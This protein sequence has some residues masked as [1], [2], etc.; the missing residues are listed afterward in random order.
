MP[1]YRPRRPTRR[2][3]EAPDSA[4]YGVYTCF[5][6]SFWDGQNPPYLG[7]ELMKAW[8]WARDNREEFLGLIPR[9]SMP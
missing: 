6:P 4:L 1:R 3:Y 2:A 9:I 7:A 8:Q 5:L